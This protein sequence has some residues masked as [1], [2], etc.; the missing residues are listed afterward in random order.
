MPSDS[1]CQ[2]LINH[3]FEALRARDFNKCLSILALLEAHCRDQPTFRPWCPYL[4]GIVAYEFEY[5]WAK[6]ERIFNELLQSELELPMRGRVLHAL[7]RSV[8]MQGRWQDAIAVFERSLAV[9]AE[10]G[11]SIAQVKTWNELAVVYRKGYTSGD[12][13]AKALHKAIAY[14]QQALA[15]LEKTSNEPDAVASEKGNVL[16]SLGLIYRCLRQWDDAIACYEQDLAIRRS[17]NDHLSMALSYGNLGEVLQKRGRGYWAQALEAYQHAL[18]LIVSFKHPYEE[19]E[20]RTN[21][22]FLYQE[23]GDDHSALAYYDQAIR[24]LEDLR[25]HV[26]GEEGQAGFFS[27]VTDTYANAILACL[28]NRLIAR[29]FDYMERARARAF[30]DLLAARAPNLLREKQSTPLT[31]AEVQAALPGETLLLE[32]FT[33]G[34]IEAQDE[35]GMPEHTPERHRFPPAKTLLIAVT[36]DSIQPYDLDISPN[37]LRPRRRESVVERHF[38]TP[39]IRRA[40]YDK[41]VAPVAPLLKDQRRVYLVPHGPLHYIPFQALLAPD[42]DT[43][44]RDNGPQLIYAPSASLLFQ[45]GRVEMGRAPEA[46]LALGY[47]G[48]GSVQLRFAEDEA[49][50]IARITGGQARVGPSPK[51]AMFYVQAANYRLIHI[52]CHGVFE[53]E[54]PLESALLIATGE[55]LTMRDVLDHLQVQCDLVTLSTCESGLSHVRRGDELIGFIRAF[56][57]A[58]A[59]AVIASLWRVDDRSTRLLMEQFYH[60]VQNGMGYAEAL[61]RAQLDLKRMAHQE[62]SPKGWGI[63]KDSGEIAITSRKDDEEGFTEVYYWAPFILVGDHGSDEPGK[64]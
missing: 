28:R 32:Y 27:T 4:K 26:S 16:N 47:N 2:D 8:K 33:T 45:H 35:R 59:P 18:N 55:T 64:R 23:M 39:S 9:H 48:E 38:L 19:A 61:K 5:D 57:R 41:L 15:A 6:A 34:L 22:A 12:F 14:C 42:G 40:L 44:L 46:A 56:M 25:A 11:Q 52:S 29:A 24:L 1:D 13:D 63:H 49:L 20:A 10:L 51:R 7:G 53:P 30:L 3:F 62:T 54:K 37:D 36:H 21:L 31:L 50:S 58:G 43:L 60:A 17:Q